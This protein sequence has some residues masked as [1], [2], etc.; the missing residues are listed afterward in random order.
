MT[1]TMKVHCRYSLIQLCK[2]EVSENRKPCQYASS[3]HSLVAGKVYGKKQI[4]NK[5]I[6]E[7][8][9]DDITYIS[10]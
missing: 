5:Q 3:G 10:A 2:I 9:L 1:D 4:C 7:N 6:F 8:I